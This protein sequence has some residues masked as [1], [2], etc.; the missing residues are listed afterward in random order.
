MQ[1]DIVI[2]GVNGFDFVQLPG[3]DDESIVLQVHGVPVLVKPKL[4]T[5]EM[6]DAEFDETMAVGGAK[7]HFAQKEKETEGVPVL[8]NPTIMQNTVAYDDL[9]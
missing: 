2:D 4:L 6:A 5:D 1:R 9:G 8:V 7:A 3:L